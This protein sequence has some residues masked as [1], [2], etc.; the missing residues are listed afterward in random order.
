[1]A[2][3]NTSPNR[4][5]QNTTVL[6]GNQKGEEVI[7][8]RGLTIVGLRTPAIITSGSCSF[9]V[10]DEAGVELSLFTSTGSFINFTGLAALRQVEIDP[11]IYLGVIGVRI[12]MSLNELADR[13]FG[14][15]LAP[16]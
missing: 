16:F 4:V 5:L 7:Q 13:V 10:V 15:V 6:N 9:Q 8:L 3:N 11:N 1:M 12:L 2:I 14:I